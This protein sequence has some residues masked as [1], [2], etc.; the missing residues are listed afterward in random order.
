MVL[1]KWEPS[2]IA[3]GKLRMRT[4]TRSCTRRW[5]EWHS[6]D[7]RQPLIRVPVP[8]PVPVCCAATIYINKLESKQLFYTVRT[9][10]VW[11]AWAEAEAKGGLVLQRS[12]EDSS[13]R[14]TEQNVPSRRS[15]AE[16]IQYSMTS[17]TNSKVNHTMNGVINGV[18]QMHRKD[19][20]QKKS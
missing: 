2:G 5:N 9:R 15:V 18:M 7:A 20:I 11:A 1:Y 19:Y 6:S 12:G 13:T 14:R 16:P 17:C 8:V 4:H 3:G 10:H